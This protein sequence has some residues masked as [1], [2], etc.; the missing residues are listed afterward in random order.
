MEGYKYI[1][2][3]V[4]DRVATIALNRPEKRNALNYPAV[5]ELKDAFT[6][7]AG[8]PEVK[9][10]RL[11]AN[12][13]VFSA[14]A[15]LEFLQKLQEYTVEDNLKDST[16]LMELFQLI[17]KYPKVV[18]AQIEG[19]AIAGGCGLV[20]VC[21]FAFSVP[22]AKFGYTEVKIGFLPAL[23]SIFLVRKLGEAQARRLLLTGDLIEATEAQKIGLITDIL[24]PE[25]IEQ[26]TLQFAEK[27]CTENALGSMD[28]T[29]RLLADLQDMPLSEALAFA[30]KMNA[31][32]RATDECK[33]GVQAFL[34]KEK[35]IW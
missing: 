21:D 29:K 5:T 23:V 25:T 6:R 26:H 32:A 19:H 4:A 18:I 22:E 28:F 14:G 31:H 34:N 3:A 13:K 7:F 35:L 1:H 8:A 20:T 16:H 15:D 33:A 2:T 10:V 27:L 11:K 12:G 30:A 24:P 17:Y 9:V